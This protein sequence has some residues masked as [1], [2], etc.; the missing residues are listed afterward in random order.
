MIL[1]CDLEP[2]T[3]WISNKIV[4]GEIP[5][6]NNCSSIRFDCEYDLGYTIEID[7][8]YPTSSGGLMFVTL[9]R[10]E[11]EVDSSL[12]NAWTKGFISG[13]KER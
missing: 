6:V 5:L 11:V 1:L 7:Y 8:D 3:A 2:I 10:D 12:V 4:S 9:Y 13:M